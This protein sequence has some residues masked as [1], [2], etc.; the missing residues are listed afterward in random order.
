MGDR[1]N[2]KGVRVEEVHPLSNRAVVYL[3]SPANVFQ[4][5]AVQFPILIRAAVD[6]L[7]RY[8]TMRRPDTT[9]WWSRP[10]TTG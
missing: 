5:G 1:E 4:G 7:K 6:F 10:V 2:V 3:V 9:G 8:K